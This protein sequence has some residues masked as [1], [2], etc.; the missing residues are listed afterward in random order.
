MRIGCLVDTTRCTGCRSCQVACK[1]SNNLAAEEH[2]SF[3]VAGGYQNPRK[4][5]PR[6]FTYISYHEL[7]DDAGR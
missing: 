7:E 3:A 1:Q 4:Y 2:K 6:T 5:T